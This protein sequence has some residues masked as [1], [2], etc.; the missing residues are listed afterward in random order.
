MLTQLH[1][2][3]T[4]LNTEVPWSALDLATADGY[5]A[6]LSSLK[7]WLLGTPQ[8]AWR[9]E[10]GAG[11]AATQRHGERDAPPLDCGASRY[12]HAFSAAGARNTARKPRAIVDF[13]PFGYDVDLLEVRFLELYADVDLFVVSECSST[14]SGV[15]KPLF[16]NE[17]RESARFRQFLPKVMHIIYPDPTGGATS[18]KE[19]KELSRMVADARNGGW[20]LEKFFRELPVIKLAEAFARPGGVAQLPGLSVTDLDDDVVA[21]QGDADEIPTRRT[22]H[23]L[24]HCDLVEGLQWPLYLPALSGKKT[25]Q[26]LQTTKSDAKRGDAILIDH[27][28]DGA[29]ELLAHIWR[30]GPYVWPLAAMIAAKDTLRYVKQFDGD[31]KAGSAA[32]TGM[33]SAFHMSSPLEPG[34]YW[35][36]RGGVIEQSFAGAVSDAITSAAAKRA[37]VTPRIILDGTASPWCSTEGSPTQRAKFVGGESA[38]GGFSDAARALALESVPYALRAY[39]KRFCFHYPTPFGL[40]G[41]TAQKEWGNVCDGS[42]PPP[43]Y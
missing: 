22:M 15:E 5:A 1:N 9:G 27:D 40:Y 16:F 19:T 7:P 3:A 26:W 12:R 4:L 33:A 37:A 20:E 32:H 17:L 38:D 29:R 2:L 34:L 31:G 25:V 14:Q 36:K 6:F 42:S 30:P 21:I 8:W 18:A 24:K 41:E 11:D 23:H 28:H 13:I 10:P 35:L 43:T 39:R